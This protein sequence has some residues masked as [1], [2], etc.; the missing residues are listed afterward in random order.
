MFGA[1]KS[2]LVTLGGL[3]WKRRFRLTDTQKYRHRKRLRAVDD[4]VDTLVAS[5]VQLR[6]LELARRAP[7]ESQMTPLEKYWVESKRFRNGIKPIHW[8][9]HWT[10]VPHGRRWEPTNLHHPAGPAGKS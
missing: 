10:K 8:V 5:G 9:P 2:T 7:K 3:V 6:A 4:V 1:F